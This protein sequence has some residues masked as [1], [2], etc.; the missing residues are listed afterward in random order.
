M[1][2]EKALLKKKLLENSV[3]IWK[4]E[5][6]NLFSYP[7]QLFSRSYK[8]ASNVSILPTPF[9]GL[10]RSHNS[11]FKVWKFPVFV[12]LLVWKLF[13]PLL[14]KRKNIFCEVCILW[15]SLYSNL[16]PKGWHLLHYIV[17]LLMDALKHMIQFL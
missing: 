4:T 11:W 6:S 13:Y 14:G 2:Q 9:N 15:T 10:L 5:V 7:A 3:T 12:P 1:W 17:I 8:D 16:F